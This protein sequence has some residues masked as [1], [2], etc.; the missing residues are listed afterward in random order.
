MT[1]TVA[2]HVLDARVVQDA[3]SE[4][5]FAHHV[6]RTSQ[7]GIIRLLA[8]DSAS[9]QAI[10]A[11]LG[12]VLTASELRHRN[13]VRVL[14]VGDVTSPYL[15]SRYAPVVPL[16]ASL[17]TRWTVDEAIGL[18]RPMAAALDAAAA[19]GFAHG[20][21]HPL[22]IWLDRRATGSDRRPVLAGFGLHHLLAEVAGSRRHGEA[23][24]DFLYVAPELLRGAGPTARSDQYALAAAVHHA[25][26]GSPPFERDTLAAL[27]G[28]HLFAHPQAVD[29]S[30]SG[31]GTLGEIMARALAKDPDTRFDDCGA[32]VDALEA[33]RSTSGVTTAAVPPTP[34]PR[35]V[36]RSWPRRVPVRALTAAAAAVFAAVVLGMIFGGALTG[37]DDE[38]GTP[39]AASAE[40]AQTSVG[41]EASDSPPSWDPA[42]RW[43]AAVDGRPTAIHVTAAGL[44][45]EADG[46]TSVV[47]PDTGEVLGVFESDGGVVAGDR[48][49][50]AA[51]GGTLRA[52]DPVD[53][54]V[55]W[56]L[57][58]ATASPPTALDDTVYGISDAEVPQLIAADADSGE[59]LWAFP[60]DEA[61][62]PAKTTVAP[63]DDFVYLAD[64]VAVYGI[65]PAGKVVGEENPLISATEAASEPL[66]LWRHEVGEKM[67]TGSLRAV[68]QGV[69][70][71]N[72]S[73]TVCLRAHVDG[74]RIW[75]VPVDGVSR[76]Q[77][78]IYEFNDRVV[79]V[80]RSAI[81]AL[82]ASTGAQVWRR[83]G[84]WRR[85]VLDGD[86]LIAV[87]RNGRVAVVSL[88]SG[89]THRPVDG[90]VGAGA[91]LAVDGDVLYAA[92]RNGDLLSVD[93]TG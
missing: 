93:L 53:G 41:A 80:T 29:L 77:P 36:S 70:V 33:C 50:V 52:V 38:T 24:D 4:V 61:A 47:D 55:Q 59:R 27:F 86:R 56:Q 43:R 11:C 26:V 83:P 6:E 45:V 39:V 91:L 76:S 35:D 3:V 64:D 13:I 30:R 34:L 82:D 58:V 79:I 46:R 42:V 92:R 14:E 74:E 60:D 87:Q 67:W 65:L 20:A 15:L 73:G 81:T 7:K 88:S 75:C 68:D 28:A 78:T 1:R 17:G 18:A 9:A 22:T 72:R 51:G 49:Y 8:A 37:S 21:V 69:V 54:S 40:Q 84:P 5:W 23:L 32:F 62:F 25:L 90:K 71:A 85:A 44:L 10:D 19:A 48:N 31:T 57:P 66:C 2:H 89:A 63:A 16:A 12:E